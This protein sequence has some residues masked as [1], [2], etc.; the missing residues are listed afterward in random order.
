MPKGIAFV[1]RTVGVLLGYGRHLLG[2]LQHRA[3]APSFNTIAVGFGTANPSTI[4]AHLNRGILRA[5]ALQRVLFAR[6]ATG[7]DIEFLA[8]STD[9]PPP[10]P[11]DA[12]PKPPARKRKPRRSL[13]AGWDD[14]KLFNLTLEELER[15]IGRRS[16]GRTIADICLDLAVVPDICTSAFWN[17]LFKIMH[18]HGGLVALMEQSF[19]RRQAF[20]AELD[21]TPGSN[22][23]W[24]RQKRD[25]VR[26]AIGFLIGEAPVDPFAPSPTPAA[27]ALATGPP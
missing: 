9:E 11:A 4:L 18:Y 13:P 8:R 14:P 21:R 2:T 5:I 22:W 12:Q 7:R 25:E 16:L 15:E 17:D 10:A 26:Q 24:L 23:D 1:L 20:V 27:T 19:H 6:A 3:A